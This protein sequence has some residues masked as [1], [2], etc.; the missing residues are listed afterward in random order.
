MKLANQATY[1]PHS[2]GLV[3]TLAVALVACGPQA[4][5]TTT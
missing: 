1:W 4:G 5:K 3:L 2:V